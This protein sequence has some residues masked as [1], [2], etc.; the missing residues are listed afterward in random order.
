MSRKVPPL[1]RAG[2]TFAPAAHRA[3]LRFLQLHAHFSH[4]QHSGPEPICAARNTEIG[5]ATLS[6]PSG[7]P[8]PPTGALAMAAFAKRVLELY[9]QGA[10]RYPMPMIWTV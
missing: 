4:L 8:D 6:P 9:I 2:A 5:A 3:Q 10:S 1:A 7:R